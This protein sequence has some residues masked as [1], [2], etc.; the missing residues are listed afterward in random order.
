MKTDT[1]AAASGALAV[2]PLLG[3]YI[4]FALVIGSAV[5]DH[6]G[7]PTAWAG[8]WLIFGGSAHL[9]AIQTLDTAGPI[10]AI[11][12][13]LLINTRLLVYSASLARH[14]GEQPRWFRVAAAGLIIDP[15]WAVAEPH[16]ARCPD[17][18]EQRR[19]FLGAG[20]ALGVGWSTAVAVGALIGTRLAWLDLK[21]VIP[22][23]LLGLVGAGL[24]ATGGR[25]VIAV[26]ASVAVLTAGWPS[27][28][29]LLAAIGAGCA[30][31]VAFEQRSRS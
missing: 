12:T 13:G 14:W 11:L 5:G 23:C 27:G 3:A 10:V 31:G 21:I 15:T 25:V 1:K 16:A 7:A 26:A 18:R 4:P 2:V 20:I 24:R 17:P 30:A 28:T 8:S 6:G 19:F 29:G 22:L 9:A